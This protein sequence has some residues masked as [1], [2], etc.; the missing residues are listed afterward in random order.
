MDRASNARKRFSGASNRLANCA[1]KN[2]RTSDTLKNRGS[3]ESGVSPFCAVRRLLHDR[4]DD[5]SFTSGIS[6]EADMLGTFE[7]AWSIC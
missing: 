2:E 5:M 3:S 4:H 1:C 6:S 7:Y